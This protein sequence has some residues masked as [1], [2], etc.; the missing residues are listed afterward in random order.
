MVEG[1]LREREGVGG[2]FHEID[3]AV[4]PAVSDRD[5]LRA[6]IESRDAEPPP[7]ELG[8]D[9]PRPGGDVEDVPTTWKTGHEEPAPERVL[10]ERQH[11][12]HPVVGRAEGSK[13]AA[14]V[15]ST[16]GHAVYS[17]A[18][19]LADELARA[20]SLAASHADPGDAVSAV[21]ATEPASGRRVYVCAGS[22]L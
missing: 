10:A 4:E 7:E 13:E 12:S 15:L 20:A 19:A 22:K 5:H 14:G 3:A 2:S 21:L 16:L 1:I 6:L 8:G 18:V 17:R 11:R 9:E